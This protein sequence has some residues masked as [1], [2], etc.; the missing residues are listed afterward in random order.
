MD[1]AYYQE[2]LER[3]PATDIEA[4][5]RLSRALLTNAQK[6]SAECEIT[7]AELLAVWDIRDALTKLITEKM[8]EGVR[9]RQVWLDRCGGE[10]RR[11][12]L[13]CH[14]GCR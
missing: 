13:F 8:L 4:L 6:V 11:C 12:L 3:I 1:T 5:V 7:T 14:C 9:L 2:R 10:P